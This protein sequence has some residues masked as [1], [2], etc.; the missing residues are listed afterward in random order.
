MKKT[1]IA[2]VA[3]ASLMSV[4]AMAGCTKTPGATTGTAASGE[5]S[6]AAPAQVKEFSAFF[7]VPATTEINKDNEIQKRIDQV[8]ADIEE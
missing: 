5:T 8:V 2:A 6:G 4:S 1:K 7:A 3:L